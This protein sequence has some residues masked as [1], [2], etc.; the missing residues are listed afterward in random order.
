MTVSN[1]KEYIIPHRRNNPFVTRKWIRIN[2]NRNLK[3][4]IITI[5][6][7]NHIYPPKAGVILFDKHFK[8]IL[9]V[10]N[11]G[12]GMKNK[13]GVPKGHIEDKEYPYQCAMRE[14]YEETGIQINIS[15]YSKNYINSIN[16]TTYYIFHT[17]ENIAINPI[18]TTEILAADF[19]YINR[20]RSAKNDIN[21]EL[22]KVVNTY[23]KKIK[24][25]AKNNILD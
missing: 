8:K 1:I 19:H 11:N 4:L 23:L 25:I 3:N 16:N 24:R 17:K 12:Y 13:W 9:I 6:G 15:K 22:C 21:K 14:F 2:D 10:K 7:K 20:I 18:D 5:N